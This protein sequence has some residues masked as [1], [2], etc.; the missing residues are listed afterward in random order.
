MARSG[1]YM[2]FVGPN[3]YQPHLHIT[4]YLFTLPFYVVYSYGI[5]LEFIFEKKKK[6]KEKQQK[7]VTVINAFNVFTFLYGNIGNETSS[8]K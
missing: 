5:N 6:R 1:K 4:Y 2:F 8:Q 7:S 3:G